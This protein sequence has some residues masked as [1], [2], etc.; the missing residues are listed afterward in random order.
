MS[1]WESEKQGGVGYLR[2]FINLVSV[3]GGKVL[4]LTAL[5][6]LQ[7]INFAGWVCPRRCKR[8]WK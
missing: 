1:D 2:A 5:G 4:V 3:A 7:V 8:W 6:V